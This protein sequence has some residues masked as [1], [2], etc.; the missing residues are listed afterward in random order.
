MAGRSLATTRAVAI[1]LLNRFDPT[2]NYISPILNQFLSQLQQTSQR[3][4]AT[5]IVFGTIRNRTAVDMVIA[6]LADCPADRIPNKLLNIIRAGVYELIYSPQTAEYAIVNEAVENAKEIAGKKQAGFVNAVLRKVAGH[7]KNRQIPLLQAQLLRQGHGQTDMR[8]VLPQTPL[9]GCQ[10]DICFLPEP[11]SSPAD[12]LAAVFSLPKWLVAD[13]LAQF[14]IEKTR[15]I[16][17]AS[18][19]KAGIYIRPNRLR[20]TTQKLAEKFRRA[21]VEYEILPD[22]SRLSK[23]RDESM[24]RLKSPG[25]VTKLPG[26]AEGLFSVQDI[27]ASQPVKL[28]NPQPDQAIL[29]FCAAPGV[30]TTQLAELTGDKAKIIATDID[31]ERLK[32]VKEN[33]DRLKLKSINVISYEQA[34]QK[35]AEIGQFDSVLL[36]VPC[37]NTGVLA[38]RIE[39]RFRL[40]PGTIQKL[41]ATQ[42][43]LLDTA[44]KMIKPQGK[45]CYS[46]CSIQAQENAKLVREFLKN[47][48]FKIT[49]EVLTLPSAIPHQNLLQQDFSNNTTDINGVNFGVPDH[50][51]GYVAIITAK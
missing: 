33:V 37:S 20:T 51:G 43:K 26:F 16:C 8:S 13:W 4:Q 39:V 11:E 47:R 18:N 27:A 34:G 46:T 45:I 38:K 42:M 5:D 40:K 35:A 30:K 36:D 28:L 3:Q 10:F 12:Y 49:S 1:E 44:A 48:N 41:A 9:T 7:I 23:G 15:Q 6:E 29:D 32:K 25:V 14:G 17:F 19:R 21:N 22:E 31:S 2:H 24:I 50:D